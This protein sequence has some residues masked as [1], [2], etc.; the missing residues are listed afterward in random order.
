M[1]AS[2]WANE[3]WEPKQ[4]GEL[5][6]IPIWPTSWITTDKSMN[7]IHIASDVPPEKLFHQ[8][9]PSSRT[10]PAESNEIINETDK[11]HE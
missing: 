1:Q 7:E 6:L 11:E 3:M 10:K 5:K 9:A 4:I 8:R 2:E